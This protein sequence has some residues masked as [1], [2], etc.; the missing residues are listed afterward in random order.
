[1]LATA[2]RDPRIRANRGAGSAVWPRAGRMP[3]SRLPA[4][5]AAVMVG[6][7]REQ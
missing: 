5:H 3:V 2:S 6:D 7:A 1:M 4:P